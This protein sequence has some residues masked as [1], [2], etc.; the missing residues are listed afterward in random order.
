MGLD[1]RLAGAPVRLA[2]QDGDLGSDR[3][4]T[5]DGCQ[6]QRLAL[7]RAVAGKQRQPDEPAVRVENG[8]EARRSV[9]GVGQVEE[10]VPG[11]GL[12]DG[13]ASRTLS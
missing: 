5:A 6:G 12:V 13:R 7:V 9:V 4:L 10:L 8:V 11:S 3:D 2:P 1:C